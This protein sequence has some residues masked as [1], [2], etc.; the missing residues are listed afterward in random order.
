MIDD[1]EDVREYLAN[2]SRIHDKQQAI[3]VIGA[4]NFLKPKLVDF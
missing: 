1:R 2:I 4:L 3:D